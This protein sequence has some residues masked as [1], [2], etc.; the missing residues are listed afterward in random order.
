MQ[1]ELHVSQTL[2]RNALQPFDQAIGLH[3]LRCLK[4]QKFTGLNMKSESMVTC[5]NVM[6][7]TKLPTTLFLKGP[8]K[9]LICLKN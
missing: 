5:N 1:I 9:G 6:R 2:I 4:H 3:V 7:I 8:L